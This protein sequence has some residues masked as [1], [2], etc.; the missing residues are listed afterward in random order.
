M[1]SLIH[2]MSV[3]VNFTRAE[4]ANVA[5][6]ALLLFVECK[7]YKPI[8]RLWRHHDIIIEYVYAVM[9]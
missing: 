2:I 8:V 6:A 4:W 1:A 5:H 7:I 3:P 9:V